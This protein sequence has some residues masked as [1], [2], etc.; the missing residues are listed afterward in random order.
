DST[1]DVVGLLGW[2]VDPDLGCELLHFFALTCSHG[3][4]RGK[5]VPALESRDGEDLIAG[6]SQT[7]RRVPGVEL[8][9][10]DSHADEVGAVDALEGLSEHR[11]DAQEGR[12]FGRPVA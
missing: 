1:V 10:K 8:Q 9:R 3:D 2:G 12:A 4:L 5:L 11:L 7:L 6:D